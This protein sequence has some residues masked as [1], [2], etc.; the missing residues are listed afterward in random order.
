M[1]ESDVCRRKIRHEA[2]DDAKRDKLRTLNWYEYPHS[3][4]IRGLPFYLQLHFP[5]KCSEWKHQSNQI[6]N[7]CIRCGESD[8]LEL[9]RLF[10]RE[11]NRFRRRQRAIQLLVSVCQSNLFD[12]AGAIR[13]NANAQSRTTISQLLFLKSGH[14]A[15]YGIACLWFRCIPQ[16]I[17][18]PEF[19]VRSDTIEHVQT[20]IFRE[21]DVLRFHPDPNQQ[22][23]FDG[24]FY[25]Y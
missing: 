25:Y 6:E 3:S 14:V 17:G 23:E 2:T 5:H 9:K 21:D 15:I 1:R 8:E 13:G 7:N 4:S 11:K 24:T 10:V 19:S 12:V 16:W 18:Y 20:W 22:V